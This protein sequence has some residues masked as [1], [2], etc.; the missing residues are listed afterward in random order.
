MN[1][2]FEI[3]LNNNLF[4]IIKLKVE[5]CTNLVICCLILSSIKCTIIT[6]KIQLS[7]AIEVPIP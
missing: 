3:Y 1:L 2:K 7:E 6:H 4:Y 5:N